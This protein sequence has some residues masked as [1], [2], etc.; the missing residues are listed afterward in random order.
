MLPVSNHHLPIEH[1]SEHMLCR[2]RMFLVRCLYQPPLCSLPATL[3]Q[4]FD[5]IDCVQLLPGR[6]D[7]G[8]R[9]APSCETCGRSKPW[10]H[11][12]RC[13]AALQPC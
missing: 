13:T 6:G 1:I 8:A 11:V 4:R 3:L 5:S 10:H 12:P 7:S 2:S 9:T